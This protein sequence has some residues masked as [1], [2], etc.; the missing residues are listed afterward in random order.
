MPEIIYREPPWQ[1]NKCAQGIYYYNEATTESFWTQPRELEGWQH[2]Q[3]GSQPP[4]PQQQPAPQAQAY[5]QHP[6]HP[7]PQPAPHPGQASGP[8]AY[9]V[10]GP[11][12]APHHPPP[13]EPVQYHTPPQPHAPP[14]YPPPGYAPAAYPPSYPQGYPPGPTH[15]PPGYASYAPPP[16]GYYPPGYP[17]P[18]C[19]APPGYHPYP[20]PT[21]EQRGRDLDREIEVRTAADGVEAEVAANVIAVAS[22]AIWLGTVQ[23]RAKKAFEKCVVISGGA[24]AVAAISAATLMVLQEV[25]DDLRMV[26]DTTRMWQDRMLL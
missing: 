14:S 5:P 24:N 15:A 8:P 23:T 9:A 21:S 7:H 16:T 12:G 11:H 13:G 3:A 17:A 20:H 1:V 2:R 22:Q 19:A 18:A 6:P 4:Q 25:V 10:P 26:R